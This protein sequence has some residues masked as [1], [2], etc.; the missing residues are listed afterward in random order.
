MTKC[1]TVPT[2]TVMLHK[3]DGRVITKVMSVEEFRRRHPLD[4]PWRSGSVR[5]PR[6]PKVK[7]ADAPNVHS[8]DAEVI[9]DLVGRPSW[10]K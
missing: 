10:L 9:E 4:D 5:S 2:V 8:D 1:P 3:R 6:R 7:D